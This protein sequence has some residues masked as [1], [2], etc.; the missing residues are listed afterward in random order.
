MAAGF[1]IIDNE[2]KVVKQQCRCPKCH[3]GF[4][5]FNNDY[6]A[7]F[8]IPSQFEHK[9]DKCGY[10]ILITGTY[11]PRYAIKNGEDYVELRC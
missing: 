11:Y 9:C 10:T 2:V 4:L 1:N 3:K 8:G 7:I 6:K 5:M